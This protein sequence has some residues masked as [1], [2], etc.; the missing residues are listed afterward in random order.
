[1]WAVGS[2]PEGLV[3]GASETS[4]EAVIKVQATG[5]AKRSV[6]ASDVGRA[7]PCGS[8]SLGTQS[9]EGEA[10]KRGRGGEGR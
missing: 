7:D 1:M 3:S 6:G 10:P 5:G 4:K 9:W 8:Q 2:W